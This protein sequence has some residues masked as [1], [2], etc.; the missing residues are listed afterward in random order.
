[1]GKD[2]QI[3]RALRFTLADVTAIIDTPD[4]YRTGGAYFQGIWAQASEDP[5][6]QQALLQLLASGPVMTD[7]LVE[8]SGLAL[9][10]VVAALTKL[11][12]HDV[13]YRSGQVD[14]LEAI[15]LADEW[16]FSVELMQRWVV[17]QE[18]LEKQAG[19]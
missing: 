14:P 10:G 7:S 2:A 3:E 8:G 18:I 17:R 15:R 1:M 4:F 5:P 9:D 13:L 12:Q 16:N 6:G 19:Q 11:E